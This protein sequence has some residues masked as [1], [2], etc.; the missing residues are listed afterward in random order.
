MTCKRLLYVLIAC[1]TLGWSSGSLAALSLSPDVLRALLTIKLYPTI[2][3]P[4]SVNN[5]P[6]FRLCILGNADDEIDIDKFNKANEKKKDKPLKLVQ[7]SVKNPKGII[8]SCDIVYIAQS[9]ESDLSTLLAA[10]KGQPILT[11]SSIKKFVSRGGM[12]GLV[13]YDERMRFTASKRAISDAGLRID[14]DTLEL[15][16]KE[17]PE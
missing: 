3:W 6:E 11:I 15:A 14:A 7:A 2:G 1:C 17:D 16:L 4:E 5:R 12:L 13:I 10:L 8:N 9:E